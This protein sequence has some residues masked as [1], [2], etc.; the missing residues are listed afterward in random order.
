MVFSPAA[1]GRQQMKVFLRRWSIVHDLIHVLI[2]KCEL[3]LR[4]DATGWHFSAKG[5]LGVAALLI[6]VTIVA[7]SMRGP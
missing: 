3:G 6:I 1:S 2:E 7:F 5:A 4:K